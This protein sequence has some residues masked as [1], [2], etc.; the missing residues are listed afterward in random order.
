ML[1]VV[2]IGLGGLAWLF[3]AGLLL[4]AVLP[5]EN[6]QALCEALD[7][8][9]GLLVLLWL[10]TLLPLSL[11]LK[12]WLDR[13]L[14]DTERL[15][16]QARALAS[17]GHPIDEAQWSGSTQRAL[18]RLF[19]RLLE[20][21]DA[22]ERDLNERVTTLSQRSEREK[23]RLIALMADLDRSVVVCNLDGRILLYNPRARLQFR[24]LS[25][26]PGV[27]G[28]A[29]LIGLGRSIHGLIERPLIEHALDKLKRRLARGAN[30]PSSQFVTALAKGRLYRG[31]VSPVC[32][33]DEQGKRDPS[34]L[35]G[36]VLQLE[37]ISAQVEAQHARQQALE[38]FL[39][40]TRDSL[41]KAQRL[42]SEATAPGNAEARNGKPAKQLLERIEA[43]DQQA[44]L[45]QQ[46]STASSWPLE[47]IRA[48][49]WL[50]AARDRLGEAVAGPLHLKLP[51]QSIWLHMDSYAMTEALSGLVQH[52]AEHAPLT[53]LEIQLKPHNGQALL[54]LSL[55]WPADRP[56][57]ELGDW[58]DQGPGQADPTQLGTIRQLLHRHTAECW[59]DRTAAERIAVR[60]LL[61]IVQGQDE[62]PAAAQGERPEFFDFELFRR[63]EA[64]T[65][66]LDRALDQL[67]FTVFDLETTGLNPAAGDEIIQIGAIRV[68]NGRVLA[69]EC[70]D[71]LIDPGRDIPALSIQ[72]HGITPDQ[73]RGQPRIDEVLPAFHR[74]CQDSVLVAHNAAF[75]MRCIRLKESALGLSFDQPVLD[76]LLLASLAQPNQASH[77]LDALAERFGLHIEDRHS[78]LGDARATAEL[79]VRL[80]PLLAEQGIVTLGQA[81]AASARSQFAR[82][83]Y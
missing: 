7:G 6:W 38:K 17:S 60:L 3:L 41:H 75:D 52:L 55:D 48:E 18:A 70:F 76:T 15:L 49:D 59:L 24:R 19:N 29:E 35:S 82:I 50:A 12:A 22:S 68:V 44:T 69:Q 54:D 23:A 10:M 62:L 58:L 20:Q 9:A 27:A 47:D 37:N 77:S 11:G 36:F 45:L 67:D 65:D 66:L 32:D 28:G 31:L 74:Y 83:Q 64:N 25:T 21:R 73:V 5:A 51:E 79:L 80:I 16:E 14:T 2:M 71:Q 53:T 8:R 57:P 56:L 42:L 13:H 78:G 26:A 33:L 43:L 4:H 30:H 34:R 1:A 40:Q 63:R 46:Q 81:Q 39:A 61:P 72:I